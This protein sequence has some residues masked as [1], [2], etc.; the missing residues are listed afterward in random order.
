LGPDEPWQKLLEENEFWQT[1]DNSGYYESPYPS[2]E[3]YKKRYGLNLNNKAPFYLSIDFWSSQ[4]KTLTSKRLYVMRTGRGR[5]VILSL[6]RFAKPYLELIVDNAKQI[7]PSPVAR[8]D[9]LKRSFR[10]HYQ[11]DT[12]LEQL[13]MLGVYD[14]IVSRVGGTDK[15][16]I[17]PR[18]NRASSFKM[19][20]RDK[21]R[22][23]PV[24]FGYEG[25]EELDYTIWTDDVVFVFEAKQQQSSV[26]GL[27][28]GWHKLALPSYR[29]SKYE[30]LN[31]VPVYY[32]RRNHV[33]YLFVFPKLHFRN[34]A[35]VMN[36]TRQQVPQWI[37]RVDI[38]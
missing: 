19:L 35:V 4:P 18:G 34:D 7:A 13:R 8:F 3:S 23:E 29:F 33:V 15:Y 28:I 38:D 14:E 11:E 12:N 30:G 16:L 5:F 1:I 2:F 9:H 21:E 17:G 26:G 31:I 25:Q 24:G 6:D 36:D 37:F 32:L 20:M 27:D 22:T 10:E